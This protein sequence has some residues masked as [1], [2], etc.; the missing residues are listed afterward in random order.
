MRLWIKERFCVLSLHC[1]S[2][3]WLDWKSCFNSVIMLLFISV[4]R[5]AIQSRPRLWCCNIICIMKMTVIVVGTQ[6]MVC[7][8]WPCL[9]NIHQLQWSCFQHN[10]GLLAWLCVILSAWLGGAGACPAWL[11]PADHAKQL[12]PRPAAPVTA[13]SMQAAVS[14][15]VCTIFQCSE[16]QIICNS[17]SGSSSAGCAALQ[18]WPST[19]PVYISSSQFLSQFVIYE[20]N[21][22]D[23]LVFLQPTLSKNQFNVCNLPF[24]Y[25]R[26]FSFQI[27]LLDPN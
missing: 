14:A 18:W 11:P 6:M 23:L 21:V 3:A 8:A 24:K 22:L 17:L 19:K 26:F 4:I 10:I 27:E 13:G 16:V 12:L 9:D 7:T 1:V 25:N 2:Q 15:A 20:L 5:A